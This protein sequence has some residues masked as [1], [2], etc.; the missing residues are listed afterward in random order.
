MESCW[1]KV[2]L[3]MKE[4]LP[5][6]SFRMWIQPMEFLASDAGVVTLSCPNPFSKKRVKDNYLVEINR[7]FSQ[8][9]STDIRIDLDV[10]VAKSSDKKSVHKVKGVKKTSAGKSKILSSSKPGMSPLNLNVRR[11]SSTPKQLTLPGLNLMFESG[12]ILKKNYTFDRFVVG[13]N[14]D[15][16]YSASLSIRLFF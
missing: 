14:N 8:A 1:K 6:H 15:F 2:K 5:D 9:A 7:E 16:A 3:K 10:P 12:R 13:D 4:S 11:G